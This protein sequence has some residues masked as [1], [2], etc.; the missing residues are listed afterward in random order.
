MITTTPFGRTG[1]DS[2]RIIF[3]AAGLFQ[4]AWGQEWAEALLDQVLAAGVNHL[5]TAASYGDSEMMMGP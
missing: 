2:S 3:G 1:H 4:R 5:D